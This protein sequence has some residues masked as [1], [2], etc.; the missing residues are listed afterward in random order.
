MCSQR[1]KNLVLIYYKSV[2]NKSTQINVL[3]M[4][5]LRS[6]RCL[7]RPSANIYTGVIQYMINLLSTVYFK[8]L[9]LY[10]S[11]VESSGALQYIL[12][13]F[14]TVTMDLIYRRDKFIFPHPFGI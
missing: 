1:T 14:N 4:S 6:Y 10:R 8:I 3:S 9:F 7:V 12:H 11:R 2:Y 13:K 5:I